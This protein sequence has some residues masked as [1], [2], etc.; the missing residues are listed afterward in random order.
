[1]IT[2]PPKQIRS[3]GWDEGD[4]LESVIEGQKLIIRIENP[5]K[6]EKRKEAAKKAWK[7]RRRLES[8]E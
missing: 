3:L 2:I 5:N 4:F 7:T 1:M 6:A 8:P